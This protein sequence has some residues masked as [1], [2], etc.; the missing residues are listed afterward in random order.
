MAPFTEFSSQAPRLLS[1]RTAMT[2]HRG[3]MPGLASGLF[4][5][6]LSRS[7]FELGLG[8]NEEV[9]AC[10]CGRCKQDPGYN[11]GVIVEGMWRS[12][13]ASWRRWPELSQTHVWTEASLFPDC[14]TLSA[15]P[16]F[17]PHPLDGAVVKNE[18]CSIGGTQ[19][20]SWKSQ[21][22]VLL[23]KLLFSRSVV[24]DSAMAWLQH[25][26]CPSASSGVCP[27][28]CP[29]HR[30]YCPATSSS[31][32]LFSFCPQSFPASGMFPMTHLF[33]SDDQNTGASA[34][35]LPVYVQGWS[36]LELTG[37]ISLLTRRLSEVF[38]NTR[39]QRYQFFGIL[40]S[41]HTC[42]QWHWSFSNNMPSSYSMGLPRWQ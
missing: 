3:K 32:A 20:S 18:T 5:T 25:F 17:F 19:G 9:P 28:S 23:S 35:V 39:F 12:G 21:Q 14:V 36:P 7:C 34:S 24:C 16:A 37:L 4:W 38:S 8:I 27:S 40:P 31:D 29:L 10:F 6:N 30:W 22:V 2:G 15:S 42:H 41:L 11:A 33:S 13:K 26:P 1:Q